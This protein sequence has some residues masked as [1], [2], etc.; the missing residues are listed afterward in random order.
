MNAPRMR[1][2]IGLLLFVG[3]LLACRQEPEPG[4]ETIT[5][6]S[7][8]ADTVLFLIRADSLLHAGE[9]EKAAWLYQQALDEIPEN[10][11]AAVRS[12]LGMGRYYL[13]KGNTEQATNFLHKARITGS[14]FP[15][16][17]LMAEVFY[18]SGEL[19][20][21][22]QKKL[23]SAVYFHQ[24]A[25]RVKK[26]LV[27][28]TVLVRNYLRIGKLYRQLVKVKLADEHFEMAK[29]LAEKN[30]GTTPATF[31]DIYFDLAYCK[32]ELTNYAEARAYAKKAQSVIELKMPGD[33]YLLGRVHQVLG[34]IYNFEK[35]YDEAA[36][37]YEEAIGYLL[38]TDRYSVVA[39]T[40]NNIAIVYMNLHEYD[41]ALTYLNEAIRFDRLANS[42]QSE[43]TTTRYLN[44]G[45][46]FQRLGQPDSAL[47]YNRK[48]LFTRLK[49]FDT[50][51]LNIYGAQAAFGQ[52]FAELGLLDSAAYYYHASLNS[53]IKSFN[54]LSLSSMPDPDES[55][56]SLNLVNA[57]VAKA[58]VL[59]D[60]YE[61]NG[62]LILLQT[63]LKC[64]RLA[65]SV[66]NVYR[67]YLP[68]ED[69]QF[70]LM[71][72]DDA[73]YATSL[74]FPY[75]KGLACASA[76]L[77]KTSD[78]RYIQ[79]ALYFMERSRATRLMDALNMAESS[80]QAS[81]PVELNREQNELYRKRADILQVYGPDH[82]DSLDHELFL[83]SEKINRIKD[84]ISSI[85]PNYTITK[86]GQE[87]LGI[88][89]L[90]K[91]A[92]RLNAV[93][94]EYYCSD[95]HIFAL[96]IDAASIKFSKIEITDDLESALE[97]FLKSL[98]GEPDYINKNEYKKFV[99]NAHLLYNVLLAQHVKDSGVK[100]LIISPHGKLSFLPFE[101]L[102]ESFP[103]TSEINY[104]LPY[105]VHRYTISYAQALRFLTSPMKTKSKGNKLLAMGFSASAPGA[106][107]R[108]RNGFDGL[109]GTEEEIKSIKEVMK[110]DRNAY[111]LG[112]EASE[113]T[114]KNNVARYNI[115]H[116]AVHGEGDT[117]N[118]LNSRL[119][120][121]NDSDSLNDGNLYAHELYGMDLQNTKLVVL[122]AC[123]SGIGKQQPGEG[124]LSI[125]R[126]FAYAGCPSQV[127]SLWKID[128]RTT[129]KVMGN[130]YRNLSGGN[131]DI[132]IS[133]AQA[134]ADYLA[135][136]SEF[137]AHP[138]YWAAF[139]QVGDSV[140]I[141]SQHWK[142][143][144]V[145]VGILGL[146]AIVILIYRRKYINK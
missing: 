34:N 11:V 48:A 45:F 39:S 79:E 129:A 134:K 42:P 72:S 10:K 14:I 87:H 100:R 116:L 90:Q 55:E 102:V 84:K 94:L 57:L 9:M 24:E 18:W 22:Q 59:M 144:F 140:A 125:A 110:N 113:S 31:L 15:D 29:T 60:M 52:L 88:K 16:S 4:A 104:K 141:Q 122:S 114:L 128:D 30:P 109:P 80:N 106:N 76:L 131:K 82:A 25:L 47:Y 132:D 6:I 124:F 139:L 78:E 27:A 127:I 46:V 103:D 13:A 61:N 40:L 126:G 41:K 73:V 120:F 65:D 50:K 98:G 69:Q 5:P 19:L 112:P 99:T 70:M 89:E 38:K 66:M 58:T 121:R 137:T 142:F 28:D 54:D 63:T 2:S 43:R 92:A 17:G 20:S 23:D 118:A 105:L 95:E 74:E 67:Q 1:L 8:N 97:E 96:T 143:V 93:L 133:L 68:Y 33:F 7:T 117:L 77:E 86:F 130:F 44:K 135:R 111:Y 107:G 35:Q 64:F 71:Q 123:E 26:G 85:N 146:I 145:A 91:Q 49:I 81:I 136:A 75:H 37:S 32:R 51:D 108:F 138:Y 36:R 119:V 21:T 3:F 12:Y 101:A 53:L 83:I 56:I 62:D 115:V